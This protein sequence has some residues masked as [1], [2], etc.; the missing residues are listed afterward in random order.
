MYMHVFTIAYDIMNMYI[1]NG[2]LA[3]LQQFSSMDGYRGFAFIHILQK[4]FMFNFTTTFW[5][6]LN[7]PYTVMNMMCLQQ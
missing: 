7:F 4:V 1:L 5:N 6:C 2:Q 3:M